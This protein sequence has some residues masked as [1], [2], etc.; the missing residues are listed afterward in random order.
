MPAF[1]VPLD[2]LPEVLRAIPR[3]D[4]AAIRRAIQR[5]VEVDAHRWIQWSIK[6]GGWA[7]PGEYRQPVDT[8]D[9]KGS[10]RGV[11]TQEGGVIY[12]SSSPPLKAG[13]IEGGRRPAWIPIEP[14]AQWVRR[15][16]GEKD[17]DKAKS[18]AFAI[19][20][21]ASKVPRPGLGVLER[22]RPKIMEA[23]AE[24]VARELA[25]GR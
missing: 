19:S 22:A 14:L 2:Q 6:G 24:N 3:E 7:G 9:F 10:W 13:V 15:K 8:G 1:I 5:T 12:A 11:M 18:I 21:K 23:L 25:G 20:R 4:E 16:F 17:P